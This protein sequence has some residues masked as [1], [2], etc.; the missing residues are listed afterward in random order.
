MCRIRESPF[1]HTLTS[2]QASSSIKSELILLV[3]IASFAILLKQK[4][5]IQMVV[6]VEGVFGLFSCFCFVKH[7]SDDSTLLSALCIC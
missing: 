3:I 1:L 4:C 7:A 6:V 5:D 2:K